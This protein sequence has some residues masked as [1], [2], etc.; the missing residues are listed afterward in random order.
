MSHPS[1]LASGSR[2]FAAQRPSLAAG[3]A[4]C[5][6]CPPWAASSTPPSCTWLQTFCPFLLNH[7]CAL[8][9]WDLLAILSRGIP[10]DVCDSWKQQEDEEEGQ[11]ADAVSVSRLSSELP[12]HRCHPRADRDTLVNAALP[13]QCGRHKLQQNPS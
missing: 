10:R 8:Q 2:V 5:S 1:P 6:S 13:G 7:L 11:R 3:G 4:V 9:G 12:P